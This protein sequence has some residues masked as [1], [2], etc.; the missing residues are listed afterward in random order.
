MQIYLLDEEDNYI[1]LSVIS[2]NPYGISWSS[3]V[4]RRDKEGKWVFVCRA[5]FDCS[6]RT[7]AVLKI[8]NKDHKVQRYYIQKII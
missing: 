3:K 5:E 1:K 8:Q 2:G 7:G 4:Y 6:I